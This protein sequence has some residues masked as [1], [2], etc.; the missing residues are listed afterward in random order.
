MSTDAPVVVVTGSTRGI[1]LGLA[2]AFLA[3]GCAVVVSGR[4][5]SAVAEVVA[6]LAMR[7]E[8]SRV[9]GQACDVREHAQLAALYA[10][11]ERAFGR[12]D[13]WINNAGT[14]NDQRPTVELTPEDIGSVVDINL[15]GTMYGSHVALNRM[16]AQGHGKL[17]N[18]E[19]WG[20]GGEWKAGMTPYSTTKLGLR[21]FTDALVRECR[22]APVQIGTLGPGMVVTDL[23]VA[24]YQKGAPENWAGSRWLYKFVIDPPELVCTWLAGKVLA[25]TRSGAHYRWMS[26][27]RLLV[28]FFQPRYWRRNPVAGTPLDQLGRG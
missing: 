15:R 14:C 17:F 11:G 10:A 1:G 7:A 13:V 22:G 9:I 16:I 25:N 8:T 3:R 6:R 23:L 28:R 5:A 21:Y 20:S 27:P 19:G 18:M 24:S 2:E 4:S 26:I 12:V